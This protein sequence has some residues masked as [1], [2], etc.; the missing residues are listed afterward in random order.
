MSNSHVLRI[1]LRIN[2]IGYWNFLDEIPLIYVDKHPAEDPNRVKEEISAFAAWKK[3]NQNIPFENLRYVKGGKFLVDVDCTKLL[4]EEYSDQFKKITISILCPR[5]YP[6]AL[7]RLA[8]DPTS[9]E[10]LMFRRIIDRETGGA[11][12]MCIPPILRQIWIKNSPH[13]GIAHYLSIFLI[14]FSIVSTKKSKVVQQLGRG[15]SFINL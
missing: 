2:I 12:F 9:K 13:A 10:D 1:E 8:D 4:G 5:T 11:P 15:V 7:P 14:W 3:F 6:R